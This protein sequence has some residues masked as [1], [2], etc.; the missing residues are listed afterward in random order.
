MHNQ[1]RVLRKMVI[2]RSWIFF[3]WACSEIK[4]VKFVILTDGFYFSL[5]NVVEQNPASSRIFDLLI[6]RSVIYFQSFSHD[7]AMTLPFYRFLAI[8]RV[9]YHCGR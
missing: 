4:S 6:P 5:D 1:G 9:I 2:K 8:D 3:P 7:H